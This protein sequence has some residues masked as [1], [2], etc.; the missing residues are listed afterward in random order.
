MRINPKKNKWARRR[1]QPINVVGNLI[2]RDIFNQ[3]QEIRAQR[4]RD[5]EKQRYEIYCQRKQT[6][7]GRILIKL[8]KAFDKLVTLYL[9]RGLK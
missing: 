6:V 1:E 2:P 5:R 4:E 9:C 8:S 3:A 7:L